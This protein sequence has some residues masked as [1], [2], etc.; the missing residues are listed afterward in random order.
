M[1]TCR[2][3]QPMLLLT[4]TARREMQ[5]IKHELSVPRI[6]RSII[7]TYLQTHFEWLVGFRQ[8]TK[9]SMCPV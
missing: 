6:V 4:S 1:R 9:A 8:I 3:T 5:V 7:Y 2:D